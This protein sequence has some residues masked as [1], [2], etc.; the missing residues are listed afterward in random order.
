MYNNY[1]FYFK[2][3]NFKCFNF[4]VIR[5]YI[6]VNFIFSGSSSIFIALKKT[7]VSEKGKNLH[8]PLPNNLL[9]SNLDNRY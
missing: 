9:R 8:H 7:C 4:I 6:L 2:K 5:K 3:N 1:K